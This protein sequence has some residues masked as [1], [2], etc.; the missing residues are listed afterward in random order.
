MLS[1]LVSMNRSGS[2][3]LFVTPF[4]LRRG[5]VWIR[6]HYNN[7][8]VYITENG[9]SDRTGIIED[10]ERI[11]YYKSYINE[12]LKGDYS[13]PINQKSFEK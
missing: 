8:P 2:D 11:S 13:F 4:G 12:V 1:L 7:I 6:E 3:W 9:V 10:E 5:L